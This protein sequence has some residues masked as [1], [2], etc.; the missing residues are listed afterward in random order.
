MLHDG[1]AIIAETL[2]LLRSGL[3]GFYFEK[4]VI[5]QWGRREEESLEGGAF[6]KGFPSL[7]AGDFVL[8]T[9]SGDAGEDDFFG[10]LF[11]EPVVLA[12]GT[13]RSSEDGLVLDLEL[14][15]RAPQKNLRTFAGFDDFSLLDDAVT[16]GRQYNEGAGKEQRL[17]VRSDYDE[18]S[19][20]EDVGTE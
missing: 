15:A 6:G 10:V 19:E 2:F 13:G 11:V 8:L 16:H 3:T 1:C 20:K 17:L 12:L 14:P 4:P 5:L 7:D 18:A 9:K